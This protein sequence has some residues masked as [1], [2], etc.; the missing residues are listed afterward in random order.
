MNLKNHLITNYIENSNIL[1]NKLDLN[2]IL[3][4][5]KNINEK[6]INKIEIKSNYKLKKNIK[7]IEN[8]LIYKLI[9]RK[10]MKIVLNEII[11]ENDDNLCKIELN[12]LVLN[13][14]TNTNKCILM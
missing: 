11:Y 10:N 1:S 4:K 14:K 5:F 6:T 3:K 7:K 2:N 12:Q 13:D 8:E 9:H